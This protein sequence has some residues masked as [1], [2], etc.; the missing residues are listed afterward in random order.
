M[1]LRL[2]HRIFEILLHFERRFE[3]FWRPAFNYVLRDTLARLLTAL[4]NLRAAG[5]VG[6]ARG[7]LAAWRGAETSRP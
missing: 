7:D 2:L 4:N 3:P 6:L 5:E 1:L